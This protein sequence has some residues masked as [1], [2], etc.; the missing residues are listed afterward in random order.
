MFQIGRSNISGPP[1]IGSSWDA[2]W[3]YLV[4]GVGGGIA[5]LAWSGFLVM[6]L[7]EGI[8]FVVSILR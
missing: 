7:I 6:E 8:K 1:K 4:V 5:T 3:P 2:F